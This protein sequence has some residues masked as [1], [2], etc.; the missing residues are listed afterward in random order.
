MY[1]GF[2]PS[3][4][5]EA[6]PVGEEGAVDRIEDGKL[7]QGLHGKEQ[8]GPD[9]H[10]PDELGRGVS[11]AITAIPPI[12]AV[13]YHAAGPTIVERLAGANEKTS[14]DGAT[15][16]SHGSWS[17]KALCLFVYMTSWGINTDSYHLHVTTLQ[18]AMETPSG[19]LLGLK[20][21]IATTITI[22]G[23]F[24]DGKLLFGIHDWHKSWCSVNEGER[25][26]GRV[27]HTTTTRRRRGEQALM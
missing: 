5:D 3:F 22:V 9:N 12:E 8:H 27:Q 23:G 18:I 1:F 2:V 25:P 6:A 4:I 20:V 11:N 26:G 13:T 17:E 15:C 24:V 21:G 7:S 19:R 14:T 10:K 16:C